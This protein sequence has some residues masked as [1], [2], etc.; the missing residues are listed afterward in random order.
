MAS[1]RQ[2]WSRRQLSLLLRRGEELRGVL[3]SA[4]FFLRVS[5]ASCGFLLLTCCCG[6][7]AAAS[8]ASDDAGPAEAVAEVSARSHL[9]RCFTRSRFARFCFASWTQT[10]A[11]RASC[12]LNSIAAGCSFDSANPKSSPRSIG[13]TPENNE[14][15][16]PFSS[17]E[18]QRTWQW[19]LCT[20]DPLRCGCFRCPKRPVVPSRTRSQHPLNTLC[21]SPPQERHPTEHGRRGNSHSHDQ[22]QTCLSRSAHS[23]RSPGRGET[24]D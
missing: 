8:S 20:A 12:V 11:H 24:G 13:T 1:S 16:R 5:V 3:K 10:I 14:L 22:V 4:A 19:Q 17:R 7:A 21:S 2:R 18:E 6:A 23:H 15:E 9:T